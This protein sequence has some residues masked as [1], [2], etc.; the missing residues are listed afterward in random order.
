[1]EE[2]RAGDVVELKSG[3][4]R[5]T[6]QKII[7]K[8]QEREALCWWFDESKGKPSYGAFP[9]EVL[10]KHQPPRPVCVE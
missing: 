4:P 1:M 7:D 2:F 3:G 5:M 8:G 6:I 9:L 10:K